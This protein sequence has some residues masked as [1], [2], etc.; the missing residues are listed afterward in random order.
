VGS[1]QQGKPNHPCQER[2]PRG[3]GHSGIAER[4]DWGLLSEWG[5]G[6]SGGA[7]L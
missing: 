3:V 4:G 1:S 7:R 5:G 6:G 2:E